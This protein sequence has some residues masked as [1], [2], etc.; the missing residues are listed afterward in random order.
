MRMLTTVGVSLLCSACATVKYNGPNAQVELIDRPPIGQTTVAY[1][2]DNLVEKGMMVAEKVLYVKK[3]I[4][5]VAYNIPPGSYKQIGFDEKSD[6]YSS[7]GVTKNPFSDPFKALAIDSSKPN[8]LC[9]VTVFNIKSCYPG[10]FEKRGVVSEQGLSFQQTLIYSGR[11]GQKINISY[12]EFSDNLA[13]PAFN[14][15]VEY[16]LST[17]AL[18][19]YKGAQIEVISADNNTITY[20]VLRN[21][22][23]R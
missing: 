14:N 1:V 19:G 16:D 15:D 6:F 5:G 9:V 12:R 7:I 11:V 8:E 13:R 4:D 23:G 22:T 3:L 21:F 2:G 18:I 20:R 10:E 17:S